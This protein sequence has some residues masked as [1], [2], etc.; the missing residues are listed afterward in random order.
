M[1]AAIEQLREAH[2]NYAFAVDT[3]GRYQGAVSIDSMLQTLA[4]GHSSIADAYLQDIAPVEQ[5]M[6]LKD[7]IRCIVKNPFPLPVVDAGNCYLG[8]VTQTILLKR[9]AHEESGHE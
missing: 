9:M 4:A 6:A 5:A 1:A 8:A 3:D 7:L 2:R